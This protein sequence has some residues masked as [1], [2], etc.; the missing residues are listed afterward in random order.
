MKPQRLFVVV[1]FVLATLAA[2]NSPA[3]TPTPPATAVIVPTTAPTT[4]VLGITVTPNTTAASGTPAVEKPEFVF[5]DGSRREPLI[6]HGDLDNWDGKYI[7]PGAVLFHDGQFHMFR[8][9]SVDRPG[10]VSVGHMVS[11]DGIGWTAVP[12]TAVFT[13]TQIS[14]A[15]PGAD[16]S[17]VLVLDDGTWV[18]YFH[19]INDAAPSVIG[20]A[21]APGPQGPWIPDSEPVLMPGTAGQW[22]DGHLSWPTVLKDG[23][24]FVMFYGAEN[25]IGNE[26]I[27]RA[28]SLD[29]ISWTVDSAPVLQSSSEWEQRSINR[30]EVLQT[31]DG[32]VM[33]YAGKGLNQR[34]LAFSPDGQNWTAF[35]GNPIIG[36]RD[37]PIR[38]T[39]WDTALLY[40]EGTYF[41]YMEIGSLLS[42]DIYLAQYTG[43]LPP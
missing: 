25:Q 11:N 39:T 13:S 32:W 8:N 28:T 4:P 19:T 2:C 5:L 7:N 6:G 30:P 9:G 31:A 33:I 43:M 1:I 29:G 21:T 35:A 22:D 27:G 26:V 41:Y 37:L 12:E 42:T 18:I 36:L 14:Y 17:S 40:H 3:S 20:R 34:G 23:S 38:A 16:V 24:T 10:V 15:Q